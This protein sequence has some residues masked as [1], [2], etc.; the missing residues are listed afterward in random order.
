MPAASIYQALA[1]CRLP[2]FCHD[3]GLCRQPAF[4]WHW[5]SAVCQLSAIAGPRRQPAH[6]RHWPGTTCQLNAM[7]ILTCWQPA[8]GHYRV[9][10]LCPVPNRGCSAISGPDP[11]AG[12]ASFSSRPYRADDFRCLCVLLWTRAAGC[13]VPTSSSLAENRVFV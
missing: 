6:N 8:L 12:R 3:H 13:C 4:T 11:V 5:P 10:S 2:A 7:T 9:A 1:H